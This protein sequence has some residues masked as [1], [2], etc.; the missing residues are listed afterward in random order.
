MTLICKK[1]FDEAELITKCFDESAGKG[2]CGNCHC[3][4]CEYRTEGRCLYDCL[5]EAEQIEF[6]KT[7]KNS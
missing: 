1:G 3:R 4:N 6:L 7:G 5:D 2:E